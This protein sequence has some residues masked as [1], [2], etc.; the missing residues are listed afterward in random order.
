MKKFIPINLDRSTISQNF[1]EIGKKACELLIKRIN[2]RDREKE[3]ILTDVE[4]IRRG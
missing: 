3:N 4:L 2:D 1:E